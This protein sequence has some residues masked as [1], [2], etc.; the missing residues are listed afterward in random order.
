MTA[1]ASGAPLPRRIQ[2]RVAVPFILVTLIWSSTW[3]VIARELSSAPPAWS[4]AYRFLIAS[5]AM[6]AYAIVTRAPLRLTRE[7]AVWAASAGVAQYGLN[8]ACVYAA[9]AHIASGLVAL[10]FAL[11]IVPNSL[12]GWV[13]LGERLSRRFMVGS[14]IAVL[15]L[16]LLFGHEWRA[17]SGH[18]DAVALGVGLSLLATLGASVANVMQAAKRVRS[19]PMPSLVAWGML[20]GALFDAIWAFATTGPPPLPASPAYWLATLYLG[21]IGSAFAFPLYYGVIRA[22]GS[23]RA[24]YSSVLVPFIAMGLSTAFEGYRW[25]TEAVIG[26]ILTII[27]LVVALRAKID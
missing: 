18:A 2:A 3:L 5:A 27:G 17:A 13:A 22:I 7:Q 16:G 14:G 23:A 10:L 12:L 9:E 11:L 21:L 20:S 15:G 24:A 8:Y 6:F 26:C 4:I 25:S 1:A 19:V